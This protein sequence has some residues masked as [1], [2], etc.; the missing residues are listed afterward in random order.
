MSEKK[1]EVGDR[2]QV[3]RQG[4]HEG[5]VGK[6]GTVK[7][8]YPFSF[9]VDVQL[10]ADPGDSWLFSTSELELLP[11]YTFTAKPY[12]GPPRTLG[13]KADAP[14]SAHY[15]HGKIEPLD[16]I[17]SQNLTFEEGSIVK[18]VTRAKHSG[19]RL[20]DLEKAMWYLEAMI[21]EEEAKA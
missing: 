16:L 15:K 18:Y 6:L 12:E 20:S 1:F 17:R 14:H 13:S 7:H 10:D 9:V 8:V 19:R 21:A 2:V 5:T 4:R 3:I 11:K